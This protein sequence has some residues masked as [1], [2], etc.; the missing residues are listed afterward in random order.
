MLRDP[1][2]PLHAAQE[3]GH[4][5]A[6]PRQYLRAAP[7][8]TPERLSAAAASVERARQTVAS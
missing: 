2:W 8:G 7:S 3:L 1:Y 6:W 4:I 5:A